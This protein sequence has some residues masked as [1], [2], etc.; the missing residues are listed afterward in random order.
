ML[1]ICRN[2]QTQYK[3]ELPTQKAR[4]LRH[5]E[6]GIASNPTAGNAGEPIEIKS[7]GRTSSKSTPSSVAQLSEDGVGSPRD[8]EA[9]KDPTPQR[10]PRALASTRGDPCRTFP[11]PLSPLPRSLLTRSFRDV[12]TSPSVC[13]RTGA[14]FPL[15]SSS[16]ENF[17]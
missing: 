9:G 17:S 5:E 13:W 8:R 4:F 16:G 3:Q 6:Q 10:A 14:S 1:F 2:I 12:E 15:C 11:R 7:S